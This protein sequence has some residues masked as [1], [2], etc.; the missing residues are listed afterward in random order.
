[1][2]EEMKVPSLWD[3]ATIAWESSQPVLNPARLSSGH[4]VLCAWLPVKP[5][6]ITN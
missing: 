3:L 6:K 1:M 4:G 2:Q 5:L